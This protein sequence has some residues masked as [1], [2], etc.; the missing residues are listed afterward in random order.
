MRGT[1]G[2]V[3]GGRVASPR[4][5]V[6]CMSSTR[7]ATSAR[8]AALAPAVHRRALAAADR[9]RARR[10]RACR[11]SPRKPKRGR[12]GAQALAPS[13]LVQPA[14]RRLVSESAATGRGP[15]MTDIAT[16]PEHDREN[17]ESAQDEGKQSQEQ[18]SEERRQAAD[19]D[20]RTVT[21]SG[22][23]GSPDPRK[24]ESP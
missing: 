13:W 9:G 21:E 20:E 8:C 7:H 23:Y 4:H 18:D 6:E 19:S 3:D 11:T 22:G 16:P 5:P 24:E 14:T 17:Q 2:A 15:S 10:S 12:R 1:R